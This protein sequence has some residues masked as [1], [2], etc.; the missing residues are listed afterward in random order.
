MIDWDKHV[1]GPVMG[2]FGETATF[3]PFDGTPFTVMGIFDDSY[4]EVNLEGGM[5][6][7][8]TTPVFGINLSQFTVA[9]QRGDE[10]TRHKTG[11]IFVVR[12]VRSDGH[13]AAKLMLNIKD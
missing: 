5:G 2:V 11:E 12:E 1:L 7:P 3:S 6:I 13:G 8:T 10:L 9:P 4:Q